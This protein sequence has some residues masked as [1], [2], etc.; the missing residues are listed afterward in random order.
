MGMIAVDS[1]PLSVHYD[2][3]SLI[4]LPDIKARTN[5]TVSR[6]GVLCAQ[7]FP[8]SNAK[9]MVEKGVERRLLRKHDAARRH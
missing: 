5:L 8:T 3:L 6:I 7:A 4:S 2:V 9:K 1:R